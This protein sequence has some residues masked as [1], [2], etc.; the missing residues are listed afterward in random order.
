MTAGC[1]RLKR[2]SEQAEDGEEGA[3]SWLPAYE[4]ARGRTQVLHLFNNLIRT[5]AA[6]AEEWRVR[7][8]LPRHRASSSGHLRQPALQLLQLT[9]QPELHV[10][11]RLP[12]GRTPVDRLCRSRTFMIFSLVMSGTVRPRC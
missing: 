3:N 6:R 4:L 10:L 5:F 8:E 7:A 1:A 11:N 9:L 12:V 2:G